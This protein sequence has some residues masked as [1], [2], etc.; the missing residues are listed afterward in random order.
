M[1]LLFIFCFYLFRFSFSV[2]FSVIFYGPLAQSRM[3]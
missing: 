1:Y 2:L 3:N